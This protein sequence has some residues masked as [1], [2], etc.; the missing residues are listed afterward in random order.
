[1]LQKILYPWILIILITASCSPKRELSETE[2]KLY[3]VKGKEI[4]GAVFE[5]LSGNL[6]QAMA[7]GGVPEAV[8][9]CNLRA[10]PLVDSL[11]SVHQA[12]IKRATLWARNPKDQADTEEEAVIQ[13]YLRSKDE[14]KLLEPFVQR[15]K[16]G[17]IRFFMP[18]RITTPLCLNCH[19]KIGSEIKESDYELIKKFYPQDRATGHVEGDLRGIWSIT[20]LNP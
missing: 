14:G 3:S 2:A 5:S 10:Y 20:F 4:A 15:A 8:A 16:N 7:R 1:M 6:G 18:I 9:Y 11:S 19:G 12:R 13:K 17:D